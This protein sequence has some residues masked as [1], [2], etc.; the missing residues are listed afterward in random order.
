L[1]K[2]LPDLS[3]SKL[4]I[5]FTFVSFAF[6]VMQVFILTEDILQQS[7]HG[8]ASTGSINGYCPVLVYS[9]IKVQINL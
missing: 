9:V 4:S 6:S 7:G 3:C 5:A 8:V 2:G 1:Q